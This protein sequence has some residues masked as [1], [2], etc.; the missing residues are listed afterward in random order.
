M[1]R[2]VPPFPPTAQDRAERV[3]LVARRGV[4]H[5]QPDEGAWAVRSRGRRFVTNVSSVPRARFSTV[6]GWGPRSADTL[7]SE[8]AAG[9]SESP[10]P[11]GYT[12]FSPGLTY[13]QDSVG[14][15]YYF[16]YQKCET[17][18]SLRTGKARLRDTGTSMS[19]SSIGW[20]MSRVWP[21]AGRVSWPSYFVN[22]VATSIDELPHVDQDHATMGLVNLKHEDH[23]VQRRSCRRVPGGELI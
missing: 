4:R 1:L 10:F 17:T 13:K 22:V 23:T 15:D 6:S 18:L 21:C 2:S 14:I 11:S 7:A 9:V 8:P 5:E 20:L 12:G 19:P 16:V 3:N